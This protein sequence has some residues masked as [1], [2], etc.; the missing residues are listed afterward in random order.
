MR[1]RVN[2]AVVLTLVVA[3]IVAA[4]TRAA[5][6]VPASAP[7]PG[8]RTLYL[9]R[10][11]FYDNKDPADERVG[12]HLDSLGRAQAQLVADRLKSLPVKMNRVVSSTFVRA[13]ETGD[14]IATTLG[15][16]CA[17]D[18]LI[19]ECTPWSS[20]KDI[21]YDMMRN[22]NPDSATAELERAWAKYAVP[23]PNGPSHD[24]LV[25]HGNV[26][27]WFVTKALG[28]DTKQWGSMDIANGSIT[29][30]TIRPDSVVRLVTFDAFAHIPVEKQTFAGRGP[31]WVERTP[32]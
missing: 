23:S 7:A 19:R 14:I 4:P 13:M 20:R 26:I 12:R 2:I 11:G 8:M 18:S 28:V 9:I 5:D 29:I 31:G 24:V 32:R 1:L 10:H 15:M 25:C 27:R 6:P 16:T 3:S 30:I 17:R 22:D 21:R